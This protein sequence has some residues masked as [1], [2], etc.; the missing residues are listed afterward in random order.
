M[1]KKRVLFVSDSI[2]RKTGYA[3]VARNIIKNLVLTNKYEIGHLGLADIPT[4]VE[5]PIHYYT[6]LKD[7][8]GCCKR[9]VLIEHVNNTI[10]PEIKFL[11]PQQNTGIVNE[12]PT[13]G[14][15]IRGPN[16]NQDHY[17]Y[18]SVYYVIQHFKPDIVIPIN[19]LWGLYN[20]NHLKNRK[21]YKFIPYLAIDS[22][23][24]FPIL[25]PP[26]G[27]QGLPPID[28]IRT[29]GTT[30]KTI[31]FTQWAKDVIN[32]TCRVVTN[33]RELN[34]IEI[35]SHGV[36]TQI[37][38][39]LPEEEKKAN[40]EKYFGIKDNTF[41]IG[42][43]ARNQPRKRLD[44]IFMTMRRFIDKNYEKY[45]RKIM[46]YF[47]CS[48]EDAIGWDLQWMSSY[49]NLVDRVIFDKNLKPGL[50]PSDEQLN[51]IINCFDA[52]VLFSNS[53][54]FELPMLE[55]AAAGIPNLVSDYSAHADWG[56]GTLMYA[57]I[58]AFEHEPRTGFVKGIVDIDS[59]AHQLKLLYDSKKLCE[60]YSKRGIALAKK[61]EWSNLC[62][63][64][65]D[66]L[67]KVDI[68][69]LEEGRYEKSDVFPNGEPPKQDFSQFN[70]QH[71]PE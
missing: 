29:I 37:W 64:W 62:K 13:K 33:G 6:Q 41:L 20:I 57:R 56:R 52:H 47:H 42:A 21:C 44:A 60:D 53:G 63:Q 18:D 12:H 11:V 9:G 27:R 35:I 69:D 43:V 65:E 49:Y 3:I 68:S 40:R 61:L 26:E 55:T 2:K 32:K 66:S 50:G 54:G 34:N 15:C 71:F 67:D 7:H 51:Q 39:P 70:L 10:S 48:L 45:G 38:K 24:L 36:D 5:L 23:C 30:N 8:N 58:G 1:S 25:Q 31:V 28:T 46:C 16:I 19:D 22:D 14:M 4:P 59:A 17:G